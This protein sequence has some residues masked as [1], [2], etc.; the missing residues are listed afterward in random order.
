MVMVGQISGR[1]ETGE[2]VG[3]EGDI[4]YAPPYTWHQMGLRGP[5]PSVR[6]TIGA[7]DPVNYGYVPS[8]P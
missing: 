8:T 5:G 4:L 3:G 1:F 7:Y 2:V 6:L